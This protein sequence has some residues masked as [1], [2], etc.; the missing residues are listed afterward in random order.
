MHQWQRLFPSGKL[1]AE[2]SKDV[3]Y[4]TE[5]AVFILT[6]KGLTL[7]EIAPGV[8]IEKDILNQMDFKP[9]ISNN[10]KVMDSVIFTNQKMNVA[11]KWATTDISHNAT[12]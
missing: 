2:H 7:T 9:I 1:A 5:R 6:K 4:V 12:L 8:D 3:I 11:K 10:M